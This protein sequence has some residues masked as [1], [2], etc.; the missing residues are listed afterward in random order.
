MVV[1]SVDGRQDFDP[2]A[3]LGIAVSATREEVHA[4]YRALAARHHPDRDREDGSTEVMSSINRAWQIV[5]DQDRRRIFNTER[6][7]VLLLHQRLAADDTMFD[8]SRTRTTRVLRSILVAAAL[9]TCAVL[10]LLLLI[11][12]SQSGVRG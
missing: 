3:V 6:A 1:K 7:A 12:M 9:A 10:S 4:A 5:G 2:Y 8:A 11:A